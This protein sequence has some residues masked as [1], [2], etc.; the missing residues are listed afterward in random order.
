MW[1]D[2]SVPMAP[3]IVVWPGD[4]QFKLR[5]DFSLEHDGANVS[6]LSM[7]AHTGTHIDAPMH[8][9]PG[10]TGA[11]RFP[12]ELAMGRARVLD[13]RGAAEIG[14]E[15]LAPFEIQRGERILLRTDNSDDPR[16]YQRARDPFVAIA[17]AG[18]AYLVEQGA[19]LVGI[20]YLSVGA[21][22]PAG[23]ETHRLLLGAGIWLL[24]GLLLEH[25]D[26]GEY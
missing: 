26:P 15:H 23:G 11:D 25:A 3:G 22:S 17:P 2:V 16:R 5:R 9:V 4:P 21:D 8:Y 20:D 12:L 24:E 18:A 14:R 1:I 6:S 10:G 7:S 19:A 13:L